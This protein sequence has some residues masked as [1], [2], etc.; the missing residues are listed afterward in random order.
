[1]AITMVISISCNDERIEV[2]LVVG[3]EQMDGRRQ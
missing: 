1:M 2:V 3:D